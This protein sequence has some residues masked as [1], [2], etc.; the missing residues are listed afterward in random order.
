MLHPPQKKK[1]NTKYC[2]IVF[3][4]FFLMEAGDTL[5]VFYS[6]IFDKVIVLL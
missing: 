2:I 3:Q 4:K 1:K 6:E 5:L